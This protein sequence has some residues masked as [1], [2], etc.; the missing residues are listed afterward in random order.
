M[1]IFHH[2]RLIF[3]ILKEENFLSLEIGSFE[4]NSAIFVA[5][6]FPKS[7]ITL[8]IHGSKLPSMLKN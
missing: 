4:G 8:Q 3:N 6:N 1:I 5:K 7:K 2:I